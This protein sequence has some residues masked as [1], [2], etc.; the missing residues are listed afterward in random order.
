MA[1]VIRQSGRPHVVI[2]ISQTMTAVLHPISESTKRS[3]RA[4]TPFA[5]P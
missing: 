2:P 3:P 5:S 4:G 1:K